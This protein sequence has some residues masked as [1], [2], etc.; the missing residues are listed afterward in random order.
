MSDNWFN[1]SE[2]ELA[3][4]ALLKERVLVLDGAMGTQIQARKLG[5][6]DF[7][8]DRFRDHPRELKGNSDLLALTRPDV[9]R[10]IHDA[11][12]A[13]GADVIETNT[14]TAT[15]IAQADYG[16]ESAVYD[17][18]VAAARIARAAADDSKRQTGRPRFVAGAIGPTNRTLSI[19]P[20][21]NDPSF[22]AVTFDQVRAAYAEQVRG[23][24][25]GGVDLL[26]AETV[27]DT[28]NL[29]A[30]L[31]A[32][33]EVFA[34][35]KARVPVMLSVTITDKSGRTLSGQTIDAWWVSVAHARPFA[36]GINCALGAAEMRPYLAELA[37]IADCYVSCYPNAGLPNAFGEYDE[38]PEMTAA[39]LREFATSGLVNLVGGCCGT[40]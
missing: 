26:L 2:V 28:L 24:L 19:S 13:A 30:C 37:A 22:R 11:Y 32:I 1:Q 15:S 9:I 4:R 39:L 8:G 27:F 5:E 10:D 33:D 25:D 12:L 40:T 36:V 38:T 18:N 31:F 16:L 29:K 21:V 17:I 34:E 35:R 14:F 20:E 7:R 23:L 6:A 3:L